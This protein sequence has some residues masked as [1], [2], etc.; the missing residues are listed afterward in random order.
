MQTDMKISDIIV[1]A[2]RNSLRGLRTK[3]ISVSAVA[4]SIAAVTLL[5]ALS[6]AGK[7]YVRDRLDSVGISGLAIISK[8]SSFEVEDIELLANRFD[9]IKN[10]MPLTVALA[11]IRFNS[12]SSDVLM[13]GIGEGAE[14]LISAELLFGRFPTKEEIDSAATVIVIESSHA[15]E[16]YKRE[17]V[18]GKKVTVSLNGVRTDMTVIGVAQPQSGG[19]L[20]TISADIPGFTYTPYT[21]LAYLSGEREIGQLAVEYTGGADKEEL[22]RKITA[23]LC[24]MS[25]ESESNYEIED[26]GSYKERA[27]GILDTVSFLITAVAAVSLAVAGLCIMSTMLSAG[28]EKKREIGTMMAIGAGRRDIILSF[29]ADSAITTFTGGVAGTAAGFVA[30]AAITNST[31]ITAETELNLIV[32]AVLASILCGLLFGILPAVA[33]SR[34]DPVKALRDD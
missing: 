7:A 34:M 25:N 9:E 24:R 14:D 17:N 2:C 32:Y 26:I 8:K 31:G 5:S 19:L 21:T 29:L 16:S 15:I 6:A 11:G 18:I 28:R 27:E 4:V 12:V 33:A 23:L 22:S 13:W 20:Q 10:V 3:L 30:A 1:F